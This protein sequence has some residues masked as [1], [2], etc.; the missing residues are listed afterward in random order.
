MSGGPERY[1]GSRL[2]W[3]GREI[4]II[5]CFSCYEGDYF[6]YVFPD[7]S[8]GTPHKISIFDG[9]F[10]RALPDMPKEHQKP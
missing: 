2:A 5:N 10:L 4:E 8:E 3:Q 1:I 7:D 9:A 6:V